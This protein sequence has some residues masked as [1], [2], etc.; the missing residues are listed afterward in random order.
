MEKEDLLQ[1]IHEAMAGDEQPLPAI[2]NTDNRIKFGVEPV[3]PYSI[4]EAVNRLRINISFLGSDV[5]K[6]LVISSE[7]NEGKS[8]IAMNLWKQMAIAGERSVLIDLDMRNST[9]ATKYNLSREDGAEL[10]GTSHYL[11]GNDSIEDMILH[12]DLPEGDILPNADN[13]VNPSMLFESR[14]FTEM[15]RYTGSHY[16]Y[17]FID[18]PPLGLVSDGELIGSKCDGA[19]LCV[20][21]GMTSRRIVRNSIQQLERAGC[22]I[23]GIVLNRV[24]G[25]GKS[26]GKYYGKK[27]YGKKYYGDKYYGGK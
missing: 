9:M 22:P 27:Y 14:K 3:L 8:F 13:I 4:E 21:A 2:V 1:M 10:K 5:K 26:Y 16:R 18:A 23:L 20:R 6:I 24:G 7:P 12:T 15:M 11:S 19:I 17:V 25:S